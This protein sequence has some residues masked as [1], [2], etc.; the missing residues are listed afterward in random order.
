EI[1]GNWNVRDGYITSNNHFLMIDPRVNKKQKRNGAQWIPMKL[2][3]FFVRERGNVI[4]YEV[5]ITGSLKDP[6]FKLKDVILDVLTNV[7]IKP[8]TTPYR[9]EVKS[10][11]TEIE[12][13]LVVRWDMNRSM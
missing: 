3:M 2:I 13:S 5:P 6:K 12:N 10:I 9:F 7:F 4:D 1:H 11:E 8:P